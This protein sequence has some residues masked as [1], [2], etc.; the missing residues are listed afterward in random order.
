MKFGTH[1]IERSNLV[2]V[3]GTVIEKK[4]NGY[5]VKACGKEQRM[6]EQFIHD[7]KDGTLTMPTWLAKSKGLI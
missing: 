4:G 3:T 7:N 6:P 5:L 1:E 2:D